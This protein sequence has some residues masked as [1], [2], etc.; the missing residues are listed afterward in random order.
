MIFK[1]LSFYVFSLK[2]NS[3]LPVANASKHACEVSEVTDS[4]ATSV[5]CVI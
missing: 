1:L 5:V 3:H 4:D 2:Q